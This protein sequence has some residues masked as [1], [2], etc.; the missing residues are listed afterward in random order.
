MGRR[1]VSL[2]LYWL[3]SVADRRNDVAAAKAYFAESHAISEQL[4]RNDPAND[5]RQI[6]LMLV[7]PHVGETAAAAAIAD[8]FATHP[9]LDNELRVDMARCY[10]Q[11]ARSLPTERGD[12]A[13]RFRAK[14]VQILRDAIANG[15]SD[16]VALAT[17]PDLAPLAEDAEFVA[18]LAA[19][20]QKIPHNN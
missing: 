13:K 9:E 8:R 10:V 15:Y 16:R 2:S 6:E 7:L 4:A 5:K 17:E 20:P 11:C 14:A 19:I 12:D 3:G 1:F 18:A